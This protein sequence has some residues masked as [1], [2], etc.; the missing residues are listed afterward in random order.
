MVIEVLHDYSRQLKKRGLVWDAH[1]RVLLLVLYGIHRM[2]K[3]QHI[4]HPS[5][6]A[7]TMFGIGHFV[8]CEI[9]EVI[10]ETACGGFAVMEEV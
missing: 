8:R 7:H 10:A 2:P 4:L 6:V 5:D 3:C 9:S 1:N